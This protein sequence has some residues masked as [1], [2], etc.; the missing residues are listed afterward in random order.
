MGTDR[1]HV[2][3]GAAGG[4]TPRARLAR[5]QGDVAVVGAGVAGTSTVLELLAAH[6]EGRD[7]AAALRRIVVVERS[8]DLW[9]GLPY[10]RRSGSASLIVTPLR[11]FLPDPLRGAFLAWLEERAAR[12]L[13]ADPELGVSASWVSD[14]ARAIE[15]RRWEELFVPRRL[16]GQFLGERVASEIRATPGVDVQ[17]IRGE[18]QSL[19]HESGMPVLSVTTP[20]GQVEVASRVAVLAVGSPPKRTLIRELA[21][22]GTGR[23]VDDTHAG[24]LDEL[25]EDLREHLTAAPG[26][27]GTLLVGANADALE[28]LHAA[29]RALHPGGDSLRLTVLA[30]HGL[31]DA[32]SV[33]PDRSAAYRSRVLARYAR[34]TADAD[35]TAAG[36]HRAIEEDVL[37]ALEEGLA[38]QDTADELKRLTHELLDRLPWAEQEAFVTT[39]GHLIN[40]FWRPTGGDYQQVATDL[41]ADDRVDVIE[42]SYVRAEDT[43]DGWAVVIRTP[44]GAEERLAHRYGAIVNCAGFDELDRT[45][46]PFLRSLLD[47]GLVRA[48][49]SRRGLAVDLAFRAAPRVHVAG[50]L[51][52]G[53]LTTRLRV[54]HLESCRRI[55]AMAPAIAAAVLEDLSGPARDDG[56]RDAAL[57]AAGPSR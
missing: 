49:A 13:A 29:H 39:H 23:F 54:W 28:L 38:E 2:E 10:G 37:L 26:A 44:G 1:E 18:A 14:H 53:N 4:M 35:L 55:L 45:R 41:L 34:T 20:D 9:A 8:E 42:G 31:P 25:L 43:A 33:R 5:V 36:I 19:R 32:W 16:F 40:R 3:Q 57:A 48:T 27:R 12:V 30:P 52:A 6:R 22:A 24:S 51:L 56:D 47:T 15:E 7:G 17:V 46:D 11:D 50:P 21:G